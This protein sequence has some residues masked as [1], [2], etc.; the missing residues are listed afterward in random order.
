LTYSQ[1]IS[2]SERYFSIKKDYTKLLHEFIK[3]IETFFNPAFC[4]A[5][6]WQL[7]K[8]VLNGISVFQEIENREDRLLLHN[9]SRK[10][11][12]IALCPNDKIG[13]DYKGKNKS[14]VV[15]SSI[16]NLPLEK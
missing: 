1:T 11:G 12:L 9:I 3:E 2:K 16:G 15:K 10:H 6:N 8:D 14:F 7:C 5:S 13:I 4:N